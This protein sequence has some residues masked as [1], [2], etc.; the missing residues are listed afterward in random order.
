MLTRTFSDSGWR[1]SALSGEGIIKSGWEGPATPPPGPRGLGIHF[2]I[3][4]HGVDE[5]TSGPLLAPQFS[6]TECSRG[7]FSATDIM[8]IAN[9][10]AANWYALS[11]GVAP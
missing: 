3:H 4:F 7:K 10:A 11:D 1:S 5:R 6:S 9:L 8:P 2:V